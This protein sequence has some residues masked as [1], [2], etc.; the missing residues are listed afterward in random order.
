MNQTYVY[1]KHL[2]TPFRYMLLAELIILL[3]PVT[4]II[5]ILMAEHKSLIVEKIIVVVIGMIVVFAFFSLE[6]GVLYLILIKR[7]KS[8]RVTLTDDGIEY[9]N[10]KKK[11]MIPYEDIKK[12]EFP[13]IKY[14]GGWVKIIY[15]GGNIRLT[16][17][18]ENIGDF[19]CQLKERID[20]RTDERTDISIYNDKKLFSFLKTAV[21]ADESW[22]RLYKNIKVMLAAYFLLIICSTA[23]ILLFGNT[24]NNKDFIM[25]STW[26][27]LAGYVFSEIII[28]IQVKKRVLKEELKIL[29]RKIEFEQKVFKLSMLIF[30]V[31]YLLILVA[32]MI[33]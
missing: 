15:K 21:F 10:A 17:V 3:A 9:M 19:I 4:M 8:I 5:G 24:V 16:V 28:G 31:G 27:T 33:G 23:V 13:S 12:L 22:A 29:P 25:G 2:R 1:R 20:E 26:A 6:M 14:T 11:I 18:L 32:I 30:T 7:F